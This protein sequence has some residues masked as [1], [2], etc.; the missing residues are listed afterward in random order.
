VIEQYKTGFS[1]PGDVPFEDLSV[2]G[3]LN[4][5]AS[6]SSLKSE[7]VRGTQS[8]RTKKR[9]GF[10]ALFNTAKVIIRCFLIVLSSYGG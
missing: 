9:S 5:S 7:T 4:L 2:M 3:G 10:R 8:G 1:P 6:N